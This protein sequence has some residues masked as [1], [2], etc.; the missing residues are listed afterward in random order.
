[1]SNDRVVTRWM[2]GVVVLVLPLSSCA[3]PT[4]EE[5]G[6][7]AIR[8]RAA[9]GKDW[10]LTFTAATD[11]TN[12]ELVSAKLERQ[13]FGPY[14]FGWEPDGDFYTEHYYREHLTTSGGWWGQQRTVSA[15]VRVEMELGSAIAT[16]VDC[17]DKPPF[18][19]Y[20]D[21]WVVVA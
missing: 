11:T 3:A 6:R 16:S 1:M 8:E 4:I 10:F 21:E 2:L 12:R 14:A 7:S 17:P 18:S 13:S 9:E 5:M 15:C 20:T 19:D